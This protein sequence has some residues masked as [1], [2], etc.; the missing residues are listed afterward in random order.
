MRRLI[1]AGALMAMTG[2]ADA[3]TAGV[4]GELLNSTRRQQGDSLTVCND[5]SSKILEF[6]REVAR[7][8]ASALLLDVKFAQGFKGFPLSGDGFMDELQIA[9]T[10]TCDLLMGI[11]VQE[12]SPFPDWAMVT[13]PYATIPFVLAVK[14]EGWTRL[15]DI[16]HD[17]MI[18]TAIQSMGEMVYITW[19][20]QQP[21][22]QRWTR[23]PYADP[24]LMLRRVEDGRLAGML[25][26][27]PVLAALQAS[28]PEARALH[29]IE[30]SPVPSAATRVGALVGIRD[31][32]LRSQI[33]AAIDALVADGTIA[34]IMTRFGYQGVAGEGPMR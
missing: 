13:R 15:G 16:P 12:D 33:D 22:E 6:D 1:L 34:E 19:N 29:L 9:M 32:Y 28:H 3:Q 5:G 25:L 2:A 4:P 10:N 18:G 7:A 20:Q 30:T 17:R 24:E 23:L 31:S 14:Q 26:W 21:K 8:I 11:S 27:Q